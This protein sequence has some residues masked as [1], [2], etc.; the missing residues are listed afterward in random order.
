MPADRIDT[1]LIERVKYMTAELTKTATAVNAS[2]S[3]LK[4]EITPR[5]LEGCDLVFIHILQQSTHLV[6]SAPSRST[7]PAG[8]R[9]SW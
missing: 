1:K 9:C 5:D 3:Y 2:L 4:N 8:A 7:S 6:K